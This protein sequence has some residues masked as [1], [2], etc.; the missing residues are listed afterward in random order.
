MRPDDWH[1]TED[2]DD[3]L[4]RAGDFLRSRP[5]LHT[6][7]LTVT[8]KLRANGAAAHGAEAPVFGRLERGGEVRATFYQRTPS[9]PLSLTRVTREQADLLAVRLA[10]LG[11]PVPG[12]SAD[13]DS[14]TA[15]AEAWQRHTDAVPALSKRI[16]LYR[17]GA[18][19]PPEPVPEGRGRTVGEQDHAHV[20]R[21]CGEFL[22]AV[23][24]VP[25]VD[26]DSWAG[27]RFADK[28]FTFWETPDGTPVSMAAATSMIAGMVRVDPVY[29][30][31]HLRGRGYA[32]AVTVEVSRA[33]LT[34]GATDVVL[35][36]DPANAAS[37]ALYQRIGY[38]PV[39]EWAVYDFPR[40]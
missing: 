36:A 21:W 19:T 23:G 3:F 20:V 35:F 39:T 16:R 15:F 25:T 22:D 11:H 40:N 2:I 26:A 1:L 14:A 31:A 17:L 6:M 34:A 30:P 18:L 7:P 5:A 8:E 29:T 38:V 33:A 24:E 4:A 10:D 32:G 27:S 9:G 12:V 28:H 37:N 13:H